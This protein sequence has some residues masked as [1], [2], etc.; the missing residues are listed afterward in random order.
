[1]VGFIK[2]WAGECSAWECDNLNHMNMRHYLTKVHQARQ[3]FFIRHGLAKAFK[4]DSVSSVRVRDFHIKYLGEAR[5]GAPLYIETAPLSLGKSDVSLCHVMYHLS[6]RLAATIVENVEHISLLT[7]ETFAWSSPFRKSLE[8]Y[9][10]KLPHHARPRGI[11]AGLVSNPLS[12]Q[13]LK[14]IG[15]SPAAHG[16]MQAY[17]MGLNGSARPECLLGRVTESVNHADSIYPELKDPEFVAQGGSAALLEA[18]AF[19]NGR[20][21]TGDG[22]DFYTAPTDINENTRSFVHNIV[23]SVTGENVFSMIA[24]GGLFNLNTRKLTKT[25][26]PQIKKLIAKTVTGLVP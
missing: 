4:M 6:G 18:H 8:D 16:V 22:F 3:M 21:E 19:L 1:M 5:P 2:T 15:L 7:Q 13:A 12:Q 20:I 25:D 9:Q 10:V 11:P 14:N 23:N 17:E 24:V 26:Q